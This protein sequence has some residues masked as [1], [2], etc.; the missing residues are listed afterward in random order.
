MSVQL[1]ESYC[2]VCKAQNVAAVDQSEF[3]SM[4]DLIEARSIIGL[5]KAKDARMVK[6]GTR[7]TFATFKNPSPG[8]TFHKIKKWNFIIIAYVIKGA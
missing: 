1:H 8:R 6:V 3:S 2:K 4:C 5:K 7:D